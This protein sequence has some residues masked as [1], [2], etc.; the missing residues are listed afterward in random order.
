MPYVNV[1]IDDSD[2]TDEMDDDDLIE[3]VE[4]RG[5]KV[6]KNASPALE[7]IPRIEHLIDCGLIDQAKIEAWKFIGHQLGRSL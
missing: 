2:L 1:W 6:Y 5:Y 7:G 4:K 3:I